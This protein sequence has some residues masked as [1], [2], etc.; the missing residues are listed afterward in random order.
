MV[1]KIIIKIF[2]V[3][4]V[5]KL[6]ASGKTRE[7]EEKLKNVEQQKQFHYFNTQY[8][9]RYLV[10]L[11]VTSSNMASKQRSYTTEFKKV[12]FTSSN[13]VYKPGI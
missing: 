12:C 1:G 10:I 13:R 11:K 4:I 7:I 5:V 3:E 6:F 9:S 2:L 8:Q